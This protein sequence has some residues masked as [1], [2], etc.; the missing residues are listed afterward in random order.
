MY[1]DHTVVWKTIN[2]LFSKSHTS[3][4][5]CTTS[6]AFPLI[7]MGQNVTSLE[8]ATHQHSSAGRRRH[9][10]PPAVDL[11]AF[12]LARSRE[13]IANVGARR[14]QRP[15]AARNRTARGG[16]ERAERGSLQHGCCRKPGCVLDVVKWGETMRCCMAIVS[17]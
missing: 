3:H 11:D 9:A 17:G 1:R 4:L 7:S 5:H 12:A 10:L 6:N 2:D 8:D 13:M 14:D 15:G 16:R